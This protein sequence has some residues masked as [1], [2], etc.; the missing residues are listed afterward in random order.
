MLLLLDEAHF[1]LRGRLGEVVVDAR[2]LGDGGRRAR[3]VAR[4]HDGADAHRA[5]A[6]EPLGDP[7]LH[8]VLEVDD[9]EHAISVR[10]GERSASRIADPPRRL[11]HFRR[12]R[13]AEGGDV[14]ADRVHRSFP[15]AARAEIRAAHPRLRAEGK[16]VDDSL[17]LA[18]AQPVSLL[19]EDDDGASLGR[20]V[21]EA[22]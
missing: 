22:R 13:S 16:E 12:N 18:P 11:H 10:D 8:H 7:A 9:A 17:G 5:E 1:R 14:R 4:D 20:L 21:G 19:E 2:F 6:R 3:V 15:H